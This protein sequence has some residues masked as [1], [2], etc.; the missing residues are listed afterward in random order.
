MTIAVDFGRKAT[1]QT[2]STKISFGKYAKASNKRPWML[3]YS[4][5]LEVFIFTDSSSTHPQF[6]NASSI[7]TDSTEL[8]LLVNAVSAKILYT[9]SFDVFFFSDLSNARTTSEAQQK[10]DAE[11][12]YRED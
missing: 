2:I 6:V 12:Q 3:T 11:G 4:A 9:D 7:Y 8:L 5:V 10:I 1:K